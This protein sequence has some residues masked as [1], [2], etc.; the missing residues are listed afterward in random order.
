MH[1]AARLPAVLLL[2]VLLLAVGAFDPMTAQAWAQALAGAVPS[3]GLGRPQASAPNLPPAA[4]G[5]GRQCRAAIRN[6]AR[7]AGI[8]HPL[9]AAIG[10][11]ESG[12]REP[13]GSI[14]PWPWSINAEGE[15]HVFE[16]KAEAIAAV[17]AL[18]AKG[19]RSIDVGCMQVNLLHH[20]DAFASLD[21]AF[22]PVANANYAARF[23]LQLRDETGAWPTATA[24]YHSATPDLGADYARRVMAVLP[25]EQRQDQNRPD[26]AS[27]FP[28]AGGVQGGVR[29]G[30]RGGFATGYVSGFAFHPDV[31]ARAAGAQGGP[32]PAGTARIIPLPPGAA[33]R[34]LGAYRAAPVQMATRPL[35]PLPLRAPGNPG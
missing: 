12:R 33:G 5:P 9:M 34:G 35:A 15:D 4:I 25:E 27:P 6:A 3:A 21:E 11:V 14:D 7:A 22:D 32:L 23:L 19:L 16:S 13:D 10:R 29:G 28:P 17:R 20:P 26:D 31:L 24:W 18:Q 30:F 1:V 8:P 2:A